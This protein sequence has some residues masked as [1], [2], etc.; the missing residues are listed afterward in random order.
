M[1]SA[2]IYQVFFR[3]D[4]GPALQH[5]FGA[6]GKRVNLPDGGNALYLSCSRIDAS[7]AVYLEVTLDGPDAE[8]EVPL[9]IPHHLVIAISG[10]MA[11]PPAG[12]LPKSK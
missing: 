9:R 1:A 8:E 6:F 10:P 11:E 4:I 5:F 12:I 3:P 2:G 7:N